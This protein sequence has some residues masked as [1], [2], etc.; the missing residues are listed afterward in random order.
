[1]RA[2]ENWGESGVAGF[3]AF[4]A[5]RP[6]D[7]TTA[8]ACS[9]DSHRLAADSFQPFDQLAARGQFHVL[10]VL[11]LETQGVDFALGAVRPGLPIVFRHGGKLVDGCVD[12]AV[13]VADTCFVHKNL[14]CVKGST[15][16]Q[17][18]TAPVPGVAAGL[19][20]DL[21]VKA[22]SR[23]ARKQIPLPISD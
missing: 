12:P 15:M 19:S 16:A 20:F 21:L 3:L 17:R 10:V 6:D 14:R 11:D 9:N 18:S 7:A 2:D 8:G 5:A 22:R 13:Q 4:A 23:K 1:M